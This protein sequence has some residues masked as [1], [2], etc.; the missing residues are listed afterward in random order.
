MIDTFRVIWYKFP[1]GFLEVKYSTE[2]PNI[3]ILSVVSFDNLI[4]RPAFYAHSMM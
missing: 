3:L 2:T 1:D 4:H